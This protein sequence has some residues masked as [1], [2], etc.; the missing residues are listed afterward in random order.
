MVVEGFEVDVE[1]VGGF[2]VI[3]VSEFE[4]GVYVELFDVM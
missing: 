1:F 2:V 3:V 4:C